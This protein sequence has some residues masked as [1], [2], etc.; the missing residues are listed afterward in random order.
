MFLPG[1]LPLDE[2][3]EE[4]LYDI[5]LC[6]LFF[7]YLGGEQGTLLYYYIQRQRLTTLTVNITQLTYLT[8][9]TKRVRKKM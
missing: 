7:I 9:Q 5:F 8:K 3:F 6:T 1:L 2:Q 4:I